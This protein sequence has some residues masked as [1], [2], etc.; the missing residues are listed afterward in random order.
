MFLLYLHTASQLKPEEVEFHIDQNR[1]A[2]GT[3]DYEHEQLI[4]RRGQEFEV[5]VTFNREFKP[6]SDVVVLQFVTGLFRKPT[7]QFFIY[8]T[9]KAIIS[10]VKHDSQP[11]ERLK[12]C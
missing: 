2:H 10:N 9:I 12:T 11:K 7:F 4:I 6:D 1:K 3:E 5:T 8:V